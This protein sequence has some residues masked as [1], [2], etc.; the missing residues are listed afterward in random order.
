MSC[1]TFFYNREVVQI[2]LILFIVFMSLA[3]ILVGLGLYRPEHTELS[4]IGFFFMF[5]LSMVVIG[6]N[7]TYQTG[8]NVTITNTHGVVNGS[9][10]LT[11]SVE[12]TTYIHTAYQDSS[13]FFTTHRL[14]YFLAVMAVIGFAGCFISMTPDRLFRRGS[15]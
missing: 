14:G 15:G 12:T 3:L 2:E 11:N 4:M 10:V 6:D 8:E 7:L 1:L 9:V 5:L 13:G